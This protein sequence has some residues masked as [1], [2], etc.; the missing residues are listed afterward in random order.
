LVWTSTD[1]L[2]WDIAE[3][4]SFDDVRLLDVYV[5]ADGSLVTVAAAGRFTVPMTRHEF[6][7]ST[8]GRNWQRIDTGIPEAVHVREVRRGPRG[9]LLFARIQEHD[10]FW[11]SGDGLTWELTRDS[12]RVGIPGE[13]LWDVAA[14]DSGFVAVGETSVGDSED[15]LA[16]VSANGRDWVESPFPPWLVWTVAPVGT[17]WEAAELTGPIVEG[18]GGEAAVWRSGHWAGLAADR[19]REPRFARGWPGAEMP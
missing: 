11:F 16:L 9:Y 7:R 8:D 1:G 4:E 13:I 10:E 14:G 2:A 5:A 3:P 15:P 12:S 17:G 19:R 6:L 18:T